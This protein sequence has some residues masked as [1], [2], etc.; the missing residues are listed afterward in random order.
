MELQYSKRDLTRDLY[1]VSKTVLSLKGL[2]VRY[3]KPSMRD[4][5]DTMN[6]MWCLKENFEVK[7]TPKSF[8]TLTFLIMWV[9]NL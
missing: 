9:P 7:Y 4:A 8:T 3:T 6:S 1:K 5:F 2:V